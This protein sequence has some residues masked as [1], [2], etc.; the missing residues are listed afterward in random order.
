MFKR[1]QNERDE[2][3]QKE[4]KAPE[5]DAEK[6]V[7]KPGSQVV[8]CIR[9]VSTDF[10][11]LITPIASQPQ[12]PCLRDLAVKRAAKLPANKPGA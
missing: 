7:A 11:R 9:G 1:K 2:E 3:L 5:Q 12:A 4:R 6:D 8:A 10:G